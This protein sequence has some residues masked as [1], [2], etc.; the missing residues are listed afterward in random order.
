MYLH[1]DGAVEGRNNIGDQGSGIGHQIVDLVLDEIAIGV[2]LETRYEVR[3]KVAG[4]GMVFIVV[5]ASIESNCR[6]IPPL[7][8]ST[9]VC[10]YRVGLGTIR[11]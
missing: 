9:L 1:T 2:V 7:H 8:L 10:V 3:L 11:D 5:C 6:L 4:N